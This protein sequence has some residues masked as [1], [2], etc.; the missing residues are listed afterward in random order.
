MSTPA[1]GVK[2]T[3]STGASVP[4]ASAVRS[5]VPRDKETHGIA[6]RP[7][8]AVDDLL[9]DRAE[10]GRGLRC[11]HAHPACLQELHGR[12]GG[13]TAQA[14]T[15]VR[16]ASE[17]GRVV[18]VV[19]LESQ[20][21]RGR[22]VVHLIDR[23]VDDGAVYRRTL[24]NLDAVEADSD[25]L[26]GVILYAEFDGVVAAGHVSVAQV[27]L[28]VPVTAVDAILVDRRTCAG[29]AWSEVLDRKLSSIGRTVILGIGVPCALA[30]YENAELVRVVAR[31]KAIDD[32]LDHCGKAGR[33]VRLVHNGPFSGL[34]V[35]GRERLRAVAEIVIAALDV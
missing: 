2:S 12:T 8:A 33:L 24:R 29:T 35:H 19:T 3:R 20:I 30:L 5:P 14:V 9:N 16:V 26:L 22:S 25:V 15:Y 31:A 18:D 27:L 23:E 11:P 13:S 32:L 28:P 21:G 17:G 7:A 4:F 34:P 6:G 1:G 10:V